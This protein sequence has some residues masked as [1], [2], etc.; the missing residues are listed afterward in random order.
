MS[1]SCT[2]KSS[3]L[4][5]YLK[6]KCDRM[7]MLLKINNMIQNEVVD[8]SKVINSKV[9]SCDSS[10]SKA[11]DD[12]ISFPFVKDLI[13]RTGFGDDSSIMNLIKYIKETEISDCNKRL[14]NLIDMNVESSS[15][16]SYE[17]LLVDET[18]LKNNY[19]L[20]QSL[21]I[22][23]TPNAISTLLQEIFKLSELFPKKNVLSF[24]SY[25]GKNS[26]LIDIPK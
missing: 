20:L 11:N 13:S 24:K 19:P 9:S 7:K 8:T 3:T 2:R 10:T 4:S 17:K 21:H 23:I 25:C 12:A 18:V 16:L 1:N 15:N 6:K 22:P 26:T 14:L 5:N